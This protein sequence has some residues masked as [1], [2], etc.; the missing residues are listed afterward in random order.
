M[1]QAKLNS[2]VTFERENNEKKPKQCEMQI[3]E[4]GTYK[5]YLRYIFILFI[6]KQCGGVHFCLYSITF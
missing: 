6:K 1:A 3:W 2:N 5:K 4:T